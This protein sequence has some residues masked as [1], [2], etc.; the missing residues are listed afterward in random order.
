MWWS[1]HSVVLESKSLPPVSDRTCGLQIE[2]KSEERCLSILGVYM[3]SGE[4]SQDVYDTYFDSVEHCISQ[5]S[6]KGPLLVLGDLN[7]HLGCRGTSST[8]FRD[9]KWIKMID[10]HYP[11][12]PLLQVPPTPI[13]LVATPPLLTISPQTQMPLGVFQTALLWKSILLIL[14]TIC[15]SLAR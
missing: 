5:L 3:T 1:G 11:F 6:N 13:L 8:N 10:K 2:L 14:P 7:A 9:N 12:A 4:Q 15:L